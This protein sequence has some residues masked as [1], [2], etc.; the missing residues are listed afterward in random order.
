MFSC[1][2]DHA[3]EHTPIHKEENKETEEAILG[4]GRV[5]SQMKEKSKEQDLNQ[6]EHERK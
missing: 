5:H 4:G 3:P 6:R 1:N 2:I